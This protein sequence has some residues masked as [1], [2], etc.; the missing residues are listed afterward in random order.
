MPR[1]LFHAH[2]AGLLARGSHHQG[3]LWRA[4]PGRAYDQDQNAAAYRNFGNVMLT[5]GDVK[6]AHALW[7]QARDLFARLGAEQKVITVQGWIDD[8]PS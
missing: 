6:E 1:D 3:R 5:R 4:R 8:L 2:F 7:V